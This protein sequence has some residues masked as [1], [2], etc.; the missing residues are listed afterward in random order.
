M[1]FD[2]RP[3]TKIGDLFDREKELNDLEITLTFQ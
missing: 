1:L 3:K 2:P